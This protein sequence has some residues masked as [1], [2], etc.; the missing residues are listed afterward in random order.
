MS[1]ES[2][3]YEDLIQIVR[4]IES[5]S[6]FRELH[7][8]V[9]E[10]EIDLRSKIDNAAYASQDTPQKVEP[11][12]GVRRDDAHGGEVSDAVEIDMADASDAALSTPDGSIVVRSPMVGTFYR[13]PEPG[14]KPFV[15]VGSRVEPDTTVCII[16]V[17]KLMS[18][19]PAEAGGIVTHI[20]VKDAEFVQADQPLL[21][22]DPEG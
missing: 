12:A 6:H 9:G 22:I 15:D 1:K 18:S 13:A 19:I 11:D 5:S 17:M 14:A 4:L 2:L 20:L 8:R 16:E 10:I 21:I 7:L 3:T